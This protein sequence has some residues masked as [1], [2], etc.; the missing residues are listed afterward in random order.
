MTIEQL[1]KI[2]KKECELC[3]KT[4]WNCY[5]NDHYKRCKIKFDKKINL[6]M[7]E[8]YVQCALCFKNFKEINN[9]HLKTIH[10]ITPKEYDELYPNNKRLS[11][12]TLAEKNHFKELTPEMSAKLKFSHTLNGYKQKYGEIEGEKKWTDS[13]E[14]KKKMRTVDRYIEIYGD[15]GKEIFETENKNRGVTLDKLITKYGKDR[16]KEIF[17][18][19]AN[20]NSLIHYQRKYGALTGMEKWIEKGNK[21]SKNMRK[22]PIDKVDEYTRYRELVSRYTRKTIS[23]LGFNTTGR[24]RNKKHV[25]HKVSIYSGFINNIDPIIIGS[26]FNLEMLSCHDNCVKQ[27]KN[28]ISIDELKEEFL[29]NDLYTSF[30]CNLTI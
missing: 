28:S 16:G 11:N 23:L 1:E 14:N 9:F 13:I 4:F 7:G 17:N 8:D 30:Y 5:F 2:G 24:G 10:N 29:N 21:H 18:S 22:I 27:E 6:I 12:K 15:K 19:W 20:S 3:N 26:I 25:D